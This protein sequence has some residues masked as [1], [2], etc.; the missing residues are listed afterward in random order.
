MREA[1]DGAVGWQRAQ[2]NVPDGYDWP[3]Y[4]TKLTALADRFG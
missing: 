4:V 1:H 3:A 2:A